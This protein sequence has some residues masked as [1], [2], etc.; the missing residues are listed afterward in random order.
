M[1]VS[2]VKKGLMGKKDL[3]CKK[4]CENKYWGPSASG[5]SKAESFNHRALSDCWSECYLNNSREEAKAVERDVPR[6]WFVLN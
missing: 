2:E 4:G 1:A 6:D 3:E 5:L